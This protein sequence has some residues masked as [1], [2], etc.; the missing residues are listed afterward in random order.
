MNV[1]GW[2]DAPLVVFG[3]L[4]MSPLLWSCF[5]RGRAVRS[6]W[7]GRLVQT[8]EGPLFHVG[9]IGLA[10]AAI[11]D[12]WAVWEQEYVFVRDDDQNPMG[13]ELFPPNTEAPDFSL[14]SLD[15]GGEV[16]LSDFRGHKPVVLIFGSFS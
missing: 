5:R 9:V 8:A 1:V 15:E 13:T 2:L 10:I 6:S 3:L 16:R 4:A 7:L 11:D 12:G 14:A